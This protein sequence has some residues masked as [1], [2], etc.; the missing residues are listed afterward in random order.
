MQREDQSGCPYAYH[1]VTDSEMWLV[2]YHLKKSTV[3][4]S[5]KDLRS[6]RSLDN[7][8]RPGM[9]EINIA[10]GRNPRDVALECATEMLKSGKL[11]FFIDVDKMV[12]DKGYDIDSFR[13]GVQ[14]GIAEL[15]YSILIGRLD[16]KCDITPIKPGKEDEDTHL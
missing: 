16:L 4:G 2:G 5:N 8:R 9:R 15:L 11:P 10:R 7:T 1:V 13:C 6:V 12:R 3:S 14:T